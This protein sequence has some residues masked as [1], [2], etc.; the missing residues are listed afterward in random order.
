MG[1]SRI[2]ILRG[3]NPAK[4]VDFGEVLEEFELVVSGFGLVGDGDE[5]FSERDAFTKGAGSGMGDDEVGLAAVCF[6]VVDE[7]DVVDV[8]RDALVESD[9]CEDGLLEEALSGEA[10]DLVDKFVEE[11]GAD[12]NED[13]RTAPAKVARGNRVVRSAHWT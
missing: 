3:C 11:L 9:L 2:E 8:L 12:G 10:V 4:V 7:G 1:Q 6:D 5:R 13:H